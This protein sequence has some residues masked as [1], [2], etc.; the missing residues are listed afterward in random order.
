LDPAAHLDSALCTLVNDFAFSLQEF[1]VDCGRA[2]FADLLN[3]DI[4]TRALHYL[5]AFSRH[6]IATS[7]GEP[8]AALYAPLGKTGPDVGEFRLHADLYDSGSLL[9]IFDEV[10]EDNT[11]T[12][13]F[14]P[15]SNFF[16]LLDQ[17]RSMDDPTRERIR[18]LFSPTLRGDRFMDFAELVHGE[19][20]S[21][22]DELWQAMSAAQEV[23]PLKRGQGYLLDD[24]QW[25]HGRTAPTGGVPAWRSHRLTF[26]S[27]K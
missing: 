24:R 19:A 14:L 18:E 17:T 1:R 16:E 3:T 27:R 13:T 4:S 6:S 23:V 15:V 7:E 9:N 22:R 12:S 8:F 11:G 21:W 5:L 25:L 20:N 10:A 26:R 2:M